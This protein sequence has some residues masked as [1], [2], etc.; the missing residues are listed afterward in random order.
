M[1]ESSAKKVEN[2]VQA[3][4][5]AP[6]PAPPS[7]QP[8][9]AGPGLHRGFSRRRR[10]PPLVGLAGSALE[11]RQAETGTTWTDVEQAKNLGG[12]SW[13]SAAD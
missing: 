8:Y 13:L 6:P 3:Q 7:A 2:L 4:W 11:K 12:L 9:A 10:A 1:N 5:A